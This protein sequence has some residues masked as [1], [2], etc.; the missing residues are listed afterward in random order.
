MRITRDK[1]PCLA[2]LVLF[3]AVTITND[4]APCFLGVAGYCLPVISN[5][6]H[7]RLQ[8][9][10]AVIPGCNTQA[11]V[12]MRHL[13][14]RDYSA[15]LHANRE[16][17]MGQSYLWSYLQRSLRMPHHNKLA[18]DHCCHLPG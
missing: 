8:P 4:I 7:F 10:K 15:F 3:V 14:L 9:E 13:E 16:S 6:C 18:T 2:A 1:E 5:G 17:H 12:I 11:M